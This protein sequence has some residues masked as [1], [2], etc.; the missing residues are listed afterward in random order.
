MHP[1]HLKTVL[2]LTR[3]DSI[4]SSF[5]RDFACMIS[6]NSPVTRRRGLS[7]GCESSTCICTHCQADSLTVLQSVLLFA[8]PRLSH[9]VG[10]RNLEQIALQ[11]ISSFIPR[12]ALGRCPC[13][14]ISQ[15]EGNLNAVYGRWP[16]LWSSGHSSW[17]QIR[18]SRV[19]FPALPEKK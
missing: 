8:L 14:A 6:S 18:R 2:L 19:R 5:G 7:I 4:G 12:D 15:L 10:N 13:Y 11:C 17:L 9:D 1:T 3:R 16:P